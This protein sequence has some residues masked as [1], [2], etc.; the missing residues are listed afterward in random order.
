M[1]NDL[2]EGLADAR[3]RTGDDELR[4]LEERF[5]VAWERMSDKEREHAIG[6]LVRMLED[7]GLFL[8]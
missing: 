6:V 7:E 2:D 4:A 5:N 3:Q 1:S 8:H